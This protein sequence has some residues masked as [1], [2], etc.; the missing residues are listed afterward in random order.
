LPTACSI[1][2]P[3]RKNLCKPNQNGSLVSQHSPT[4][5]RISLNTGL[6]IMKKKSDISFLFPNLILAELIIISR[7]QMENLQ[8]QKL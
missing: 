5:K 4:R 3:C 6:C 8:L 1:I 7:H 2:M